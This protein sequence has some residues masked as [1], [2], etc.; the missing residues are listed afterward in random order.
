LDVAG[1]EIIHL[2]D[3]NQV[4][5]FLRCQIHAGVDED[6]LSQFDNGAIG[7]ANMP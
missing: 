5:H 3:P 6:L 4:A 7:T 1:N 2:V